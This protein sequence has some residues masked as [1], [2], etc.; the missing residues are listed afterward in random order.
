MLSTEAAVSSTALPSSTG[1]GQ[2]G[3]DGGYGK[4]GGGGDNDDDDDVEDD[5]V[6]STVIVVNGCFI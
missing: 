6:V 5:D 4:G 3:V 1:K 2:E